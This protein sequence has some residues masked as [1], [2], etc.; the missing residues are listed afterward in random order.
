M[1]AYI[2]TSVIIS[3]Y[4]PDEESGKESLRVAK[5][6][7]VRKVGSYMLVVELFSVI[8]RL[9]RASLIEMPTSIE[10]LLSKLPFEERV[11]ALVN[12]LILDWN[13]S[14]PSTG[15]EAK[16]LRLK[17]FALWMPEA[18]LEA[19]AM[20][21][22]VNLKTLDLIHVASAKIINDVSHDL[23]YFVTLDQDIL[24]G[25]DEIKKVAGFQP[26]TPQELLDAI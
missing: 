6:D 8:S 13:L 22:A 23:A 4:K 10:G 7:A 25:R 17:D 24:D 9:Y 11:Y 2:D 3:A 21:P 5:L 20:V 26:L 14:C 18:M 12:A 1:K 19:C 15:F 16:Q